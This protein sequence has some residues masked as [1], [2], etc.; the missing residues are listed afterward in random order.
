MVQFHSK[1][2]FFCAMV[3]SNHYNLNNKDVKLFQSC[4]SIL[5]QFRILQVCVVSWYVCFHESKKHYLSW[6][7][8]RLRTPPQL[9]P[10]VRLPR[11]TGRQAS[12][13]VSA[14]Q[15]APPQGP[16]L[17]ASKLI[18]P[19]P[20]SLAAQSLLLY[21]LPEEQDASPLWLV[22]ISNFP[23]LLPPIQ[24]PDPSNHLQPPLHALL[25]GVQD[26]SPQ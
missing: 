9:K 12:S 16:G 5:L 17:P 11:Q 2:L 14:A 21:P 15:R 13:D 25:L 4:T 18:A 1:I 8:R 23:P 26:V 19:P 10:P 22:R 20:P 24:H 3:K 6:S 7:N